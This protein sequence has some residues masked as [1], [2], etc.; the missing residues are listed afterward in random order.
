MP[1][2]HLARIQLLGR[3]FCFTPYNILEL[4][5]GERCLP[6]LLQVYPRRFHSIPWLSLHCS[7]VS[8]LVE[9]FL[10]F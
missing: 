10:P 1:F 6:K 7:V 4:L 9:H 5:S 2:S 3:V 8:L